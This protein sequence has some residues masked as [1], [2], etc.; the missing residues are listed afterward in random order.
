MGILML[1]NESCVEVSLDGS[2]GLGVSWLDWI[3]CRTWAW[4]NHLGSNLLLPFPRLPAAH[5]AQW[6]P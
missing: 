6:P 5:L 4:Q 3:G 1:F 2:F